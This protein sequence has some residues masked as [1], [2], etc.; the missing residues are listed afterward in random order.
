ML[1]IKTYAMSFSYSYQNLCTFCVVFV[2]R[3][4]IIMVKLIHVN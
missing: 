4:S 2:I 1:L 3:Q